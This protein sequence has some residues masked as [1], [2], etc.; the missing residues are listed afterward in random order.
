MKIKPNYYVRYSLAILGIW[1]IFIIIMLTIE[2]YH[3]HSVT[4]DM[5]INEART[6]FN[7]D[8]AFRLWGASHGGLYVPIDDKTP[9]NPYLA[10]VKERD[11]ETPSGKKLTLMNPAYMVRQMSEYYSDLYGV[12]GHITSLKTLRPENAPDEWET[13]ALKAFEKGET[14]VM[15]FTKLN[16]EQ[17]LRLM[18]PIITKKGCLKCHGHQDY[19]EG[20]IRGGISISL[21]TAPYLAKE[22]QQF[23]IH[24]LAYILIWILG[25]GGIGIGL[26]GLK[27][28][29]VAVEALRDSEGSLAKAQQIAQIGNWDWNIISNELWWSDEIYNIFGLKPQEFG[30]TYEAFLNS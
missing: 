5:A 20:D 1:T 29:W 19:K 6:H 18:Q 26:R 8:Q 15:E 23:T 14:E 16:G 9:P 24:I 7:R 11:I 13:K 22:R 28:R 3:D 21:P 30:A 17:Y 4:L 27:Q 12:K 10:H 2:L 25:I